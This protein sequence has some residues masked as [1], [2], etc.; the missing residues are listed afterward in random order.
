MTD[1]QKFAAALSE[2]GGK[3]KTFARNAVHQ[4]PG[5]DQNDVEQEL[6][7][8][9]WECVKHYDPNR[10]SRF[11]TYFQRSAKNRIITL[12]RHF[13][14]KGRKGVVT[15]LSDEAVLAVVESAFPEA[16]AEDVALRMMAVREAIEEHGTEALLAPRRGRRPKRAA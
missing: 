4:L 14:T 1:D 12:I 3:V 2:Y 6:L 16:S 11:N 15:T 8:V 7:V 10:G 9:L 13:N 5:F